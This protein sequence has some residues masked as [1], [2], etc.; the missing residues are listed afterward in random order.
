MTRR[1]YSIEGIAATILF[2]GLI[3]VVLL[4]VFGRFGLF[5]APVWTEE[6]ARWI[7]VWMAMIAIGE[8]ERKNAQLRMSILIDAFLPQFRTMLFTLIDLIYLAVTINLLWVGYKTVLRTWSNESV[9]LPFSDAVLYAS[10]PVAALFIIWRVSYR[11]WSQLA[12]GEQDDLE[13]GKKA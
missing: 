5:A 9:T 8:A 6:M 13:G 2:L 7:W 3:F 12:S 11:I 10:Y 1:K 4:Q